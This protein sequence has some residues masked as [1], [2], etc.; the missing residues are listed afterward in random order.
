MGTVKQH[1]EG[2]SM[3]F[4]LVAANPQ[5]PIVHDNAQTFDRYLGYGFSEI[6]DAEFYGSCAGRKYWSDEGS[7]KI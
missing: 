4:P 7:E 5:K 1:L 3:V 2:A 6:L